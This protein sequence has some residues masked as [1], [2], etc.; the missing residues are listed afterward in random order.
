MYLST[1]GLRKT[2]LDK[3]LKSPLSE[4]PS[5]SYMVNGQKQLFKAERQH[6]CD[7]YWSLSKKFSLR[8]SLW[9]IWKSLVLFVNPL[10]AD[11]KYSLLNRGHLLQHFQMSLSQKR[12]IFSEFYFRFC[13]LRYNFQH[14][15]KNT[16]TWCD[17]NLTW[18]WCVF[19]L[20]DFA[21]RG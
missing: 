2:W 17:V 14:F 13:K 15:Q 18:S 16:W 1:Y 10:T 7:I 9:V 4:F 12:K 19:E 20:T 6:L 11:D 3:R 8:K 21:K 5:T